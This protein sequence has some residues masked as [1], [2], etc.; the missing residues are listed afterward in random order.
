MRAILDFGVAIFS[1]RFVAKQ[2]RT[3]A[4]TKFTPLPCA[5]TVALP[6]PVLVPSYLEYEC[7]A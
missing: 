3:G 7:Q 2:S 5:R 4:V 6:E 1:G